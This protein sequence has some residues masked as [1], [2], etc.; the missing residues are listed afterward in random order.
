MTSALISSGGGGT[1]YQLHVHSY[2]SFYQEF[3][4][5]DIRQAIS[6]LLPRTK[7]CPFFREYWTQSW[8]IENY[9]VYW[10]KILQ[11]ICINKNSAKIFPVNLSNVEVL[12]KEH[13][14]ARDI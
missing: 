7:L 3:S 10:K 2:N 8:H 6:V 4:L 13:K 11:F 9:S 12:K 14:T 5:F 1:N